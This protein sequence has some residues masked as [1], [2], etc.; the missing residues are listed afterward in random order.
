MQFIETT[1][2][3]PADAMIKQAFR[4]ILL[5]DF[6]NDIAKHRGREHSIHIFLVNEEELDRERDQFFPANEAERHP[7]RSASD[8]DALG[9]Y[10]PHHPQHHR[11]VIKISPEKIM[12]AC[13][14]GQGARWP[15]L[16]VK[17]AY[18]AMFCAVV[19]HELAHFLMDHGNDNGDQKWSRL[20]DLEQNEIGSKLA[21]GC[22]RCHTGRASASPTN[23][24]VV[25]ARRTIEESLANGFV[26]QQNFSTAERE[27]IQRF[28]DGSPAPYRASQKWSVD[29]QEVVG[30]ARS[31]SAFKKDH[32][33]DMW[34]FVGDER[35]VCAALEH[36]AG[37]MTKGPILDFSA[38][39][40]REV[41]S[42]GAIYLSS[43]GLISLNY[44]GKR[45]LGSF[46]CDKNNLTSLK[47]SPD[48]VAGSFHCY[49][50]PLTS[51]DGLPKSIMGS[52]YLTYTSS[53]P[54]LKLLFVKNLHKVIFLPRSEDSKMVESILNEYLGRGPGYALVAGAELIR[55]GHRENARR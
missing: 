38:D 27:L 2:K 25:E 51:F 40:V 44:S 54:L 36:L 37:L 8:F 26:M 13:A 46:F 47:G 28:I 33:C 14:S 19:I 16:P 42:R 43:N 11:P 53:L 30:A 9:L 10:F 21:N 20:A 23:R 39:F 49:K 24:A 55:S 17:D 12:K 18:P 6:A 5:R 29:Y 4:R 31:W 45:V 7:P 32:L 1:T 15:G 52:I 22:I 3:L 50:N 41:E 48:E 35:E 34:N